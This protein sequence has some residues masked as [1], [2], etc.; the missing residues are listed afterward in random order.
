M[1]EPKSSRYHRLARRAGL[2]SLALTTGLLVLMAAVQPGW[3]VVMYALILTAL[4]ELITFPVSWYRGF[5]LEQ[6]YELSSEPFAAWFR[7]HLKGFALV[8]VFSGAIAW[9]VYRLMAASPRWWWVLAAVAGTLVTL[10]LARLAP[11]ILL[12][13]FYRFTPLE[14]PALQAR[15]MA[16]SER[17]GVPVLGVFEWGL[18]EKTRRANAALVGSGRTRRILLSDTLL[19]EYSDDEIEVILAHELAHHVHHDI[20]K[21]ILLEFAL[22][23]ASGF[24]AATVLNAAWAQIGL[25]GPADPAGLPVLVLAAGAVMLAATPLVLAF[26]R[27]NERRADA[28]AIELTKRN[29]AFVSAMRRLGAQNLEEERPSAASVWLFYSHPPIEERIAAARPLR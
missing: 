23:L 27:A 9:G 20:G 25:Q 12:P 2:V 28:F 29:G 18:G 7:D 13:L 14:R 3:P 24:V 6:R 22:L 19:S 26:S 21:G 8:S 4:H 5:L 17:A 16:L 10:L 1:N 11:V 15:L